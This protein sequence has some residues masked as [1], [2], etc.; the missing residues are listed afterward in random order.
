MDVHENAQDINLLL[1]ENPGATVEDLAV[2]F[3]LPVDEIITVL[4]THYVDADDHITVEGP[5]RGGGWH[6]A[7][8]AEQAALEA[9]LEQINEMIKER[10]QVL[11]DLPEEADDSRRMMEESIADLKQQRDTL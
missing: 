6:P 10:E 5:G 1:K 8:L 11:K 2:R 4:D 3:D 7:K 9:Q